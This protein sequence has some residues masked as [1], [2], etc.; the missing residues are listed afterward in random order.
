MMRAV[1]VTRV[2]GPFEI[3]EREIP[4]PGPDNADQSRGLRH[5]P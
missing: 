4:N 1:Q 5:L 3:I 2:K